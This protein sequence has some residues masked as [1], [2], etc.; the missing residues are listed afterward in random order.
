MGGRIRE[1]C[2]KFAVTVL[3]AAMRCLLFVAILGR[4]KHQTPGCPPENCVKSA[5]ATAYSPPLPTPENFLT[6]GPATVP[7]H[8]NSPDGHQQGYQRRQWSRSEIFSAISTAATF[9]GSAFTAGALIAAIL[10]VNEARRQ[11]DTAQQALIAVDRPWIK[12]IGVS[13]VRL[14][15]DKFG[16]RLATMIDVKNIG[17]SPA[18]QTW[19]A[20]KLITHRSIIDEGIEADLICS[21]MYEHRFDLRQI[22]VFR[23]EEYRFFH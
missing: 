10:A 17:R 6:A 3:V 15:I 7:S 18:P 23:D 22:L 14:E 12:V 20:T 1:Y 8:Q 9:A 21:E 16:I 2:V 5:S 19:I 4:S 11:A 13:N